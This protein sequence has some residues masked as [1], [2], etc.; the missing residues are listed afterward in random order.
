[1]RPASLL[2][3]IVL[4]LVASLVSGGS[5]VS[6]TLTSPPDGITVIGMGQASAAP[7]STLVQITLS[8]GEMYYGQPMMPQ[9]MATPGAAER[10]AIQP[11]V[12]A[13]LSAGI[14]E[15]DI[16]V[17][18]PPFIGNAFTGMYG[19]ASALIDVTVNEPT[20]ESIADVISA[21]TVGSGQLRL[22]PP[23]FT[24]LHRLDDCATLHQEARQAAFDDATRLANMEADVVGV[25]LGEV[26]AVRDSM[27]VP[28]ISTDPF[29]GYSADGSCTYS[30]MSS[31]Y[32][33]F[34]PTP[35][36]MSGD[37]QVIVYAATEVTFSIQGAAT[38]AS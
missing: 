2:H 33:A 35:Y 4:V 24:I 5:A 38:P 37:P 7:D 1:M 23:G 9:P 15:S 25:S 12:D 22:A 21:A 8:G 16:N 28:T 31:I 10:A 18:V 19:P 20:S 3:A 6:Q 11:V 27:N 29:M 17:V 26:V 13:L 32:G 30:G 34:G 14:E 36:D